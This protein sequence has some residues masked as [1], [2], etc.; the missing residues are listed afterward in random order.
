MIALC[1]N[2]RPMDRRFDANNGQVVFITDD[3]PSR[4]KMD[5]L[6]AIALE[7]FPANTTAILQP[8]DQG[9]IETTQDLYRKALLRRMLTGHDA[10]MRHNIDLLG[11]I[12]LLNM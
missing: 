11:A 7:I 3:C 8:M 10:S 5:N 2:N 6:T 12:H 9:I 4:G 1:T